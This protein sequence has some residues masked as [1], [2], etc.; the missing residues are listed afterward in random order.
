MPPLVERRAHRPDTVENRVIDHAAEHGE[1]PRDWV[2]A[3]VA[4]R[5]GVPPEAVTDEVRAQ[6]QQVFDGLVDRKMLRVKRGT[7]GPLPEYLPTWQARDRLK[8]DRLSAAKGPGRRAPNRRP[9]EV[10]NRSH[11]G[12]W[13]P[14]GVPLDV[15]P[16]DRVKELTERAA[17]F[18][19]SGG[20]LSDDTRE[21]LRLTQAVHGRDN[22]RVALPALFPDTC[23]KPFAS[24]HAE[25]LDWVDS[26]GEN[27]TPRPFTA[28]WNRGSAKSSI[29]EMVSVLLGHRRTRKYC[30]YVSGNSAKA[31][32][33]IRAIADLL[34]S[35]ELAA[36]DPDLS[37]RAV[38][39][40][41]S[42]RGWRHN[43]LT[44]K[45]GFTIDAVGLDQDVR[46]ARIGKQRPD[47]LIFDDVD[48][49]L[50]SPATIEKKIGRITKDLIPTRSVDGVAI[51]FVQNI[52]HHQGIAARLAELPDAPPADFLTTRIISG[53]VKAVMAGRK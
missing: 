38:S 33:H 53:P 42:S 43:R 27:T 31:D 3:Q 17:K 7:S 24:H 39:K 16:L 5:E 14:D 34:E 15:D 13:V 12:P 47:I 51:M 30:L 32:D 4:V 52:I 37:E 23:T 11:D 18:E 19:A 49:L 40:Y 8:R 35:P 21:A 22:W 2:E 26:I 29:C 46:G 20:V 10:K 44:T 41:G 36:I 25:L 6:A 9:A 45:A 28:F 1:I 50:D 48:S